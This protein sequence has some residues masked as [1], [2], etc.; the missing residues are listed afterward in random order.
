MPAEVDGIQVNFC[1]NPACGNYGVPPK[2]TILRG[3]TSHGATQDTYTIQASGAG[4]PIIHCRMCGENP[5]PK[6][7]VAIAEERARFLKDLALA[8]EPSCPNESCSN[9]AIAVGSKGGYQSFGV[10][11]SGSRRYRCNACGK[12]FSVG[13]STTGHKQPHKNRLVFSLLMNK[14]P[15]RRICEVADID[16]KTLYGKINFIYGQCLAFAADREKRLLNGMALPRLY[17][18]ID[19]QDYVVNWTRHEDRRNV[20][21][22]AVGSADNATAYVFGMHLN[23]D[24]TLDSDLIEADAV[25]VGDYQVKTAPFRRYARC[26]LKDDYTEAVKKA[27]KRKQ[28][29][30]HGLQSDIEAVYVEANQRDDIEVPETQDSGQRLPTRGVQIHA[31]YTLYGHFFFL[32]RLF[33]GVEKLRFFLDQDSGMRAACLAA[34]QADISA[35]KADAFY[36]SIAKTLTVSEKRTAIAVSRAAFDDARRANPN[37]SDTELETLLI[38]ERIANMA[39]IGKWQDKWLIHPFPNMSEPEKA[40]CYLTDYKDYG[41]DHLARLYN[42]ASLHAIDCFFMQVRRRLSILERPISS[43]SGAGRMWHGYSAYNP[44][45]IVKMLGIFRTFYNYC[46]TGKDGKTP[47]MRLGLAKGK[48]SLEDIIYF[49]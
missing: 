32:K 31:E 12:T 2:H 24:A 23:Y 47:A 41:E 36:V 22:R 4:L 38:K 44:E 45:T 14:S 5:T 27:A 3:R 28:R 8:P 25:A 46:I 13:K 35:R 21:L 42:K 15:F 11:K 6:S 48:V 16:P 40:V 49:G 43:A 29:L 30:K 19:R 34:F 33:G 1:K 20:M 10:T 9:H 37:L 18:G 7:N 17:L 39:S 26:W